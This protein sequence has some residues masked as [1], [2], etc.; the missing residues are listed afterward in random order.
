MQRCARRPAPGSAAAIAD[1]AKYGSPIQALPALKTP[2]LEIPA[3]EIPALEIPALEI[4]ALEF[5][6]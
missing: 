2:A 3:L 5:R 1:L 4:P 6:I